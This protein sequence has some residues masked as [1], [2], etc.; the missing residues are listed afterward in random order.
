MLEFILAAA[1]A[2]AIPTPEESTAPRTEPVSVAERLLV[3][4]QPM[5]GGRVAGVARDAHGRTLARAW[6]NPATGDVQIAFSDDRIK[7]G[8]FHPYLGAEAEGFD[9]LQQL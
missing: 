5:S 2:A 8:K 7:Q 3:S 9:H 6:W 1:V 4:S